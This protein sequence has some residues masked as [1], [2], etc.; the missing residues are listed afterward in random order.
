[1]SRNSIKADPPRYTLTELRRPLFAPKQVARTAPCSV[2]ERG[3]AVFSPQILSRAAKNLGFLTF[4]ALNLRV[5]LLPTFFAICPRKK[6]VR[7][8]QKPAK[9]QKIQKKAAFGVASL[10]ST[11]A[12]RSQKMRFACLPADARY[13]NQEWAR[14]SRNLAHIWTLESN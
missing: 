11:P 10:A 9:S 12:E 5:S 4:F 3:Y 6:W 7:L 1:M 8:W 13:P 14:K 2:R